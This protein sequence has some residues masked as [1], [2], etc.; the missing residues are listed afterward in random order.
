M[1]RESRKLPRVETPQ[2]AEW[3]DLGQISPEA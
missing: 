3:P 1:A 2:L